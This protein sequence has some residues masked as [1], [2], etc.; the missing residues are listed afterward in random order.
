MIRRFLII[1]NL[2]CKTRYPLQRK[3]FLNLLS[4]VLLFLGVSTGCFRAW[5]D[6][7]T[8][9]EPRKTPSLLTAHSVHYDEEKDTVHA[10]GNVVISQGGRT[11][12][13]DKIT[14][15]R[16]IDLVFAEGNIR[17]EEP[18]GEVIFVQSL[19]MTGDLKTGFSQE[20][21][22]ILADNAK[23]AAATAGRSGGHQNEFEH[24]VYSPCSVCKQ[25]PNRPPLWQIKARHVLWDQEEQTVEYTDATLEMFGVPVGYTPYL[26][27]PDPT[28]KRKSGF[29]APSFG[30]SQYMGTALITPYYFNI[31]PHK[32]FT[33]TPILGTKTQILMGRYQQRFSRGALDLTGS[34]ARVSKSLSGGEKESNW[35]VDAKGHY[36]MNQH[37]RLGGEFVRTG[38]RTYVKRYPKL[39]IYSTSELTSKVYGEGF[40]G[41]SY[42]HLQGLSFQG[43][44]SEDQQKTIP[45]VAPLIDVNY[46][47]S[48]LW[49]GSWISMD[50]NTQALSRQKGTT[51]QR[52]SLKGGWHLPYRSSW[53]DLYQLDLTLRG[54]EYHVNSFTPT[55]ESRAI[56]GFQGRIFPQ[57]ALHWWYPFITQMKS[58]QL[59]VTPKASLIGAPNQGLKRKIPNEDSRIFELNDAN[60]FDGNRQRGLDYLDVGSRANYGVEVS[61]FG[62]G[63]G[64]S[65][66][67]MGQSYN[68]SAPHSDFMDTGLHQGASDY[69]VRLQIL[70]VDMFRLTYRSRLEREKLKSRRTEISLEVGPPILKGKMDYISI[71]KS[72]NPLSD[73][74]GGKQILLG[75]TSQFTQYWSVSVGTS[76][77]L[78]KGGGMLSQ[79]VGFKYQDECFLFNTTLSK[80]FYK[81]KDIKPGIT[82]WFTIEFKNLGAISHNFKGGGPSKGKEE[83]DENW[84]GIL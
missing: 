75:L 52:L 40:Y 32:S 72:R 38:N 14:Y 45:L 55:G 59:L 84:G 50:F 62:F 67:F 10:E 5:G 2:F 51:S 34:G 64:P 78:G 48:P 42:I 70:P 7:K 68:F 57:A 24:A 77:E 54:D 31:A 26:S 49:Q 66:L 80:S 27:H 12:Y 69:L 15:Q 25:D 79:G 36:H 17:L 30:G 41:S 16:K 53:G 37:W 73:E 71:S 9:F 18:N 60:L 81:D 82:L 63:A 28:V 61:L 11:L 76:R 19:E 65:S 23:L 13:A 43:L 4:W 46:K 39:G 21:R 74:Q 1:S 3:Q 8:R 83:T 35:H 22:M 20:V 56:K 47:S 33:V 44:G 58:A 29:L 6:V